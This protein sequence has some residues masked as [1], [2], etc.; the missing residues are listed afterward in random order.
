[1]STVEREPETVTV[2]R[3]R[4]SALIE[5]GYPVEEAVVLAERADVDLHRA[6]GLLE[7][8]C[9]VPLALRILL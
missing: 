9:S 6:I 5:A 4:Q 1:V 3:W 7:Q 8:G 2:T